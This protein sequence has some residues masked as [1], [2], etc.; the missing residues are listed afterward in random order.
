MRECLLDL[1]LAPVGV[2]RHLHLHVLRLDL[3]PGQDDLHVRHWTLAKLPPILERL[4]RARCADSPQERQG[5]VY[6][7]APKGD[8]MR[9]DHGIIL[10]ISILGMDGTHVRTGLAMASS[11]SLLSSQSVAVRTFRR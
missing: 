3:P 4:L 11:P 1:L 2:E 9:V 5:S 10:C 7:Q 8:A 6:I